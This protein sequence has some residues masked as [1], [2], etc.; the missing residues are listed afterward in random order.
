MCR[1][2]EYEHLK[3]SKMFE[4]KVGIWVN[5]PPAWGK[6]QWLSNTMDPTTYWQKRHCQSKI[7]WRN[8]AWS[9]ASMG[10]LLTRISALSIS[11]SSIS[12]DWLK[13]P[14]SG[15]RGSLALV[16]SK[17][18]FWMPHMGTLW[19]LH[20]LLRSAYSL[21]KFDVKQ[22]FFGRFSRGYRGYVL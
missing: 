15:G 6:A 13:L 4:L 19:T 3:H 21:K 9:K 7:E 8:S 17:Y 20:C 12:D 5:S 10:S 14:N 22:A 1:M 2:I 18:C 11:V 16:S